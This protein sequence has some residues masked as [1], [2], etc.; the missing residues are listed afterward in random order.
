VASDAFIPP[1]FHPRRP[2]L[3]APV[4][5]DPLGLQ[6]P[7]L[8]TARG[9]SWRRTS[10]GFYVPADVDGGVPEQRI[11][12]A[13]AVLPAVGAVTGWAALRWLGALWFDGRARDGSSE[14]AVCLATDKVR[15][16]SNAELSEERLPL[17]YLIEVDGLMV[18]LPVWAVA[19]E[20]RYA[21]TEREAAVAFDM[22]AFHDLVSIEEYDEVVAELP[23]W[24]GIPRMRKARSLLSENSWSPWEARMSHIWQIDAELPPPLANRPI[25]DRNGQHLITPD[26]LDPR[27]GLVGEYDGGLHATGSQRLRDRDRHEIYRRLGLEVVVM[28][29]GDA[30]VRSAVAVRI[31]EARSRARFE[32]ERTRTWTVEPPDWWT[33]TATVAQRRALDDVQRRRLLAHRAA[34]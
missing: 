22:A 6:G 13:A 8:S 10:Q 9:S 29:K 34:A 33:P 27:A 12:E 3:V 2:E 18:V 20:M 17:K 16:P 26:L 31:L 32:P 11:V 15:V 25:F 5:C 14:R 23:G 30:G 28:M 21:P 19:F 4:R 7:R 24:T 1:P